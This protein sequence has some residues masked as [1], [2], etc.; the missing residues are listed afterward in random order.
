MKTRR[1]EI[2]TDDRDT[3]GMQ[4]SINCKVYL[5]YVGFSLDHSHK[6]LQNTTVMLAHTVPDDGCVNRDVAHKHTSRRSNS[7]FVSMMRTSSADGD[8]VKWYKAAEQ[9]LKD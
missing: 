2:K 4:F 7:N 3:R 8:H 9:L 1:R 6:H 5:I